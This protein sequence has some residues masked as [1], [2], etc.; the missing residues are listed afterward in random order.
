MPSIPSVPSGWPRRASSGTPGGRGSEVGSS[1]TPRD[2]R[3]PISCA[4]ARGQQRVDEETLDGREQNPVPPQTSWLKAEPLWISPRVRQSGRHIAR[5][6]VRSVIDRTKEKELLAQLSRDESHQLAEAQRRLANGRRMRFS[7]M[8]GLLTEAELELFLDLL[9]EALSA[10]VRA[11]ETVIADEPTTAL[12]VTV[13]AQILKLMT[14]LVLGRGISVL[15]I[16][17]D[18]AVASQICKR[19]VVLYAGQDMEDAPADSL[20]SDPRHPY[21][22]EL[23]QSLPNPEGKIRDI[24]GEVPNLAHPPEGCRFHPRCSRATDHCSRHRPEKV[25]VSADHWVRCFHPIG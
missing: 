18:L 17:H 3:K 5:G 4:A 1:T 11:E 10:K 9:G 19:I 24:P 14:S 22:K 8:E 23:L 12:D 25:V 20:F 13:E 16:T 21:T 6:S 15:F 7:E 2:R